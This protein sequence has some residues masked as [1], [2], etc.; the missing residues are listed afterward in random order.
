MKELT[1]TIAE[2]NEHT[3]RGVIL[4]HDGNQYPFTEKEWDEPNHEPD[5]A[6][7]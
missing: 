7:S 4:G 6:V 2:W 1:G 5:P 3:G